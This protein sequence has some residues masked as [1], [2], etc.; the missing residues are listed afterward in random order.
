MDSCKELV[1]FVSDV[2]LG[3]DY[4]DPSGR[5]R[6]FAS[7]LNSL[8]GETRAVYLL[9]DIFDFWYEYKYVVPAGF[10]RTFGALASLV[11]RGVKVYFF[12][13][14]HDIWISDYFEREI[15]IVVLN[16]PAFVDIGGKKF[17]MG[18]GDGLGK[19]DLG[20]RLLRKLFYSKN[21]RVLFSALHPRWAFAFAHAWSRH[22]RL[23]K[24][25]ND[26]VFVPEKEPIY[27]FVEGVLSEKDVDY[28]VFGHYHRYCE[29]SVGKAKVMMLGEWVHNTGAAV[30]DGK[31]LRPVS[32]MERGI[33]SQDKFGATP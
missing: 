5:E 21:A 28:F 32:Y 11:D 8:P 22:N 6:R 30:F 10:V 18:H 13:G 26:Y 4:A 33:V 19:T 31:V 25:C 14:N 9:G 3:L 2:H 27:G 17:C 7:F 16:Q 20:F 15:G 12:R 23:R 1:Y 29:F 24:V